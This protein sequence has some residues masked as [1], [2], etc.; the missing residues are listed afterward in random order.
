MKEAKQNKENFYKRLRIKNNE[1]DSSFYSYKRK[2]ER[3][4][5]QKITI[6]R[7]QNKENDKGGKSCKTSKKVLD[8][9]EKV[10]YKI[11]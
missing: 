11:D 10:K 5:N 7:K 4:N 3:Y 1:E 8:F 2:K 9:S 6:I